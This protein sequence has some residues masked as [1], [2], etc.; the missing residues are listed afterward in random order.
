VRFCAVGAAA[1]TLLAQEL[2]RDGQPVSFHVW[3]GDHSQSY[4]QS[5]W[6]SYLSF[7]AGT[8]ERCRGR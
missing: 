8:L 5:H 7:H 6:S 1:D 4:W 3:P 2:R